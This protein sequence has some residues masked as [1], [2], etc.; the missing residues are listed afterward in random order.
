M[1]HGHDLVSV[2]DGLVLG[3]HVGGDGRDGEQGHHRE[4]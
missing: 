1:G 4:A 2:V 3:H